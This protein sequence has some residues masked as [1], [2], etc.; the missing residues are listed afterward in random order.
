MSRESEKFKALV[1]PE[2]PIGTLEAIKEGV[3]SVAPGLS[4]SK[5]L[6][7]VGSELE[8][9][10]KHGSHELA[11]AIFRGDSFVMYPREGKE[12][13]SL[14]GLPEQAQQQEMQREQARGGREM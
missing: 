5:I 4:L 3:Q 14:H 13:G 7:D 10:L 2:R 12:A 11:S 6:N 1:N 9:Q 8:Q